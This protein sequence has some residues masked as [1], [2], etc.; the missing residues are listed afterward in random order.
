MCGGLGAGLELA[1]V[2]GR[3]EERWRGR[4]GGKDWLRGGRARD[5]HPVLFVSSYYNCMYQ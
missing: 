5:R 3:W 1:G 2:L 4:L